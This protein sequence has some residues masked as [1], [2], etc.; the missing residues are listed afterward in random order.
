MTG[1]TSALVL[2]L[3]PV[4]ARSAHGDIKTADVGW[5]RPA[6]RM[7]ARVTTAR[8]APADSPASARRAASSPL[9]GRAREGGRGGSGGGGGGG[10][11]GRGG[12]GGQGVVGG[13]GVGVRG[14]EPVVDG[15][16]LHAR[17]AGQV[18]GQ[19]HRGRR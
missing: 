14:R 11:G 10:A 3:S 1:S 18:E 8:V 13:G 2:R 16:H 6:R 5:G 7:A 17:L 12:V 4:P 15:H 19:A 9:S